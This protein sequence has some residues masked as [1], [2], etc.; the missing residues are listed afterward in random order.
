ML[1]ILK[2]ART[3]W[4]RH[5]V[6]INYSLIERYASHSDRAIPTYCIKYFI[7]YNTER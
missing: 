6:N 2:H 5:H 4:P 7:H 3:D 1:S